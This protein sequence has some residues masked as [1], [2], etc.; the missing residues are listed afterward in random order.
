MR[1]RTRAWTA[2][3]FVPAAALCGFGAGTWA[4]GRWLVPAGSGLAAAPIALG[5]GLGAA[6]GAAMLAWWGARRLPPPWLARSTLLAVAV[7]LALL[8]WLAMRITAA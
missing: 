1:Q 5:Y 6:A 2:A 7:A 4:A 3:A 8:A